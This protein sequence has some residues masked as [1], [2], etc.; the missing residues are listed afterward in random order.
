M[1][2]A[3]LPR[4]PILSTLSH[5]QVK[6]KSNYVA[7]Y[8]HVKSKKPLTTIP[9]LATMLTVEETMNALEMS[10]A[11]GKQG[12]LGTDGLRIDVTVSDVKKVYGAIR[13][14]VTPVSGT[15]SVWVDSSRVKILDNSTTKGTGND[16][17]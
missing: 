3:L 4:V 13:Y 5:C 12:S 15:G 6:V 7:M 2:R 10:K 14:Q 17:I 8:F 1:F 9:I 16:S 11:I